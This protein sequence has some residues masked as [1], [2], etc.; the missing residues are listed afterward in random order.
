MLKEKEI[1]IESFKNNINEHKNTS[2]DFESIC[3]YSKKDAEKA[4]EQV[5]R[6]DYE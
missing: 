1:L 3:G 5:I 2:K 6:Y 4:A